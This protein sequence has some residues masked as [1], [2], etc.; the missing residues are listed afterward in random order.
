MTRRAIELVALA[1]VPALAG[2]RAKATP[3]WHQDTGYRWRQLDV[4]SGK[5]G[6]TRMDAS[7]TGIHFENSVSDSTLL[8]NR[9]FGQGAGVCLGDVD[10]DGRPDV[11]LARTE[12]PSKLY[13]NLGDWHFDDITA[14]SGIATADRH[15][16]GCALVD[17]DGDGDLDLVLLATTGPNAIFINDGHG[18]FTE[19]RDLGLDSTGRGGTTVTLA[20]VDGDGYLDLY[21]ANYK[22]YSPA[23]SSPPQS[24]TFSQTVYQD[25][26][27]HYAVRPEFARDYK[28]ITRPD[29]GGMF[30]TM[31]GE[32]DQFYRNDHGRFVAESLT[33]GRFRGAD[34]KPFAE[35]PESFALSAKFVDVNGDGAPDLYVAN[36][37][38]DPDLFFLND[39]HGVF[40]LASWSAQRQMSNSSMGVDVGDVNGDGLPDIFVTDMLSNDTHRLKTQL[41]AHTEAPKKPGD[42]ESQPQLQ[43]NTLFLNRGDGTFAEVSN[44]A[45]VQ[46]SGWS[47]S[48]MLMDVDL[49]G[50]QDILVANGHLWDL[51]DGD[52][53][54]RLQ[55]R[56]TDVMWRRQRWE[57]PKL[58]LKNVA[59]RNR[60]DST[61]E[62]VSEQWGFGTEADVS[63]AMAAADLDGDGDL[64]VVVNRLG[65]PAL[66]LRNNTS[67]PRIAV[68]LIGDA[69][70]TMGVG[71]KI[72]VVGGPAP[73]E[74][75]EVVAG[76]LYLSHSDYLAS[77]ATGSATA[78]TI[79]VDWRDGRRTT[80][81]H[82]AP[83]RL[84]EISQSAATKPPA[85]DTTRA[86]PQPLFE[87]VTSLLGGHTHTEN[88]FDDWGRQYL[89]P[90]ALSELGPGVAW[91]DADRDGAEDLIVGTGKGGHIA[92]FHNE[93]GRFIVEPSRSALAAADY[94]ALLGFAEDGA[95]RLLAGVSTWEARSD[96]EMLAQPAAVSFAFSGGALAAAATPLVGSHRA[97]TGP[98]ALGDYDGDGRL[99][100]FIGSRAIPMHYPDAPSSG[101]F[102]NAGGGHFVLDTA[103]SAL[104]AGIGMVTS[105][106]FADMNGDGHP[107]L[108]LARDWGSIVLLLNDG[109]GHFAIAPDS[110]GL[111]KWTSRWNG[112]AAGDLDGDGRLDLVATSW[113]RNTATQ[114]DSTRPLYL[115]HG[116]FGAA[117]EDEMLLAQNDKRIGGL[118]PL[119]GFPRVRIAMPDVASRIHSFAAYADATIQQVLGADSSRAQRLSVT[120]LDH[121]AFLNRGDHF[122]A[123]PL[124]SESQLAPAFY[125]GIADFN[126]DGFEDVFLAQNFSP[127]AAGTPRYD[128][129]RSILLIGDGTGRLVPLSAAQSGLTV[130][131]DQRGAAFA[132]FDGDGRL[133]L[134]VSQNGAL[135][136]LFKNRGAKPGLRIRLQ[137]APSNP[138]GIGAQVRVVYAAGK[139][140]PVREVQAGSGYWSQNGAVQVFGLAGPPI[141]VWVRWPG[142]AVSRTAVP[143]GAREVRVKQ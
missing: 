116:P 5:P 105:A 10:G 91:F 127:T 98:I 2:C 90:D 136:R 69:P 32:R 9:M 31:R 81:E 26:P 63:H 43:R 53:Q 18:H 73:I 22:A 79:E 121:M 67:A 108:V 23:D 125:A 28:L 93:H 41:P 129:G 3:P 65:A 100:L 72:K 140:G 64:D 80:I 109:H 122:E 141:A 76:G 128:A 55:N 17:V 138:D 119:N 74:E 60:G 97:A 101:L 118:A 13:R 48:T 4:P 135:T 29:L 51:M 82:A 96:S 83:N 104:L 99:D 113:G 92:V 87:D 131:G 54:E 19:R 36:D 94:T 139:M 120:T 124:P 59:Y 143:L 49:D 137:G 30:L 111:A 115:V 11:F 27:G 134:A 8:G 14:S 66:L 12:G 117:G 57:F 20:D 50:W 35:P 130:Y 68:R 70:N 45:G 15:A 6:F 95:T 78:V 34:G 47:W 88:T 110:W 85:R 132:D 58:A 112:L 46:A 62:D 21:V 77:F 75:H 52:T 106:M 71:A 123:M 89:L 38:E 86:A 7:R 61:F 33:A 24:R 25:R 103:N 1:L 84:Y 142:G 126:G 39:G 16:T 37:F 40:R 44:Y 107:D 102:H 42:M 114:V 133:D 56:T